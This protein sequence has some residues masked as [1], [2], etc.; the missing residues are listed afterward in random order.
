MDGNEFFLGNPL[1]VKVRWRVNDSNDR[2]SS[3]LG[4]WKLPRPGRIRVNVDFATGDGIGAIGVVTWDASG[5]IK[6]LFALKVSLQSVTHGELE[7]VGKGA[8]VLH[9]LGIIEADILSDNQVVVEALSSNE[10]LSWS[11]SLLFSKAEI[12]WIPRS[13]NFSAHALAKWELFNN[14]KG[15][16]NCWEV[17]PCMLTKILDH[18][19]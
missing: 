8:E 14:Y 13:K 5:G 4:R 11:D 10:S 7:A 18:Y 16:L 9:R 3:L 19:E 17:M 2:E 12:L 6:A 1:F 15:F